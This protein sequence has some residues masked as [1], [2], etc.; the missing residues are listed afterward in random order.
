MEHICFQFCMCFLQ[1]ACT[2]IEQRQPKYHWALPSYSGQE[3]RAK[4]KG[5]DWTTLDQVR[6]LTAGRR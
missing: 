1:P 2:G 5:K 3:G 6:G 4:G